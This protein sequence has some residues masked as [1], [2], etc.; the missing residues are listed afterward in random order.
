MEDCREPSF[1]EMDDWNL[2]DEPE[3]WPNWKL[4]YGDYNSEHF[5]SF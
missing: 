5:L 2:Y 3:T 4:K 1:T